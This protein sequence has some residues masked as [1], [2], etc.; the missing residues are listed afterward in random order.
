MADAEHQQANRR[1]ASVT[2]EPA[3]DREIAS[4]LEELS[5]VQGDLLTL[6]SNK[7]DKIAARDAD[8][9]QALQPQEAELGERL[10]GCHRWRQRLL[11]GAGERGLPSDSLQSL[12]ASLPRDERKRLQPEIASARRLARLL[13]HQSLTNWV[14]VQRTLLH[15]SQMIEIIATGGRMKPTYGESASVG[16]GGAIV[17]QAV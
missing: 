14:V 1:Q 8:A 7:R 5:A 3:W 12:T 2:D 4:L 10:M 17:D 6:L 11:A 15:L 9:L 16:S 13:Q